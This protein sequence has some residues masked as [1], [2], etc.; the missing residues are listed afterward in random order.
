MHTIR[1]F[2]QN[3]MTYGQNKM[4]NWQNEKEFVKSITICVPVIR[5]YANDITESEHIVIAFTTNIMMY[6]LNI[7]MN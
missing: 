5:A 7:M 3:V 4:M 6:E 1:S 2:S